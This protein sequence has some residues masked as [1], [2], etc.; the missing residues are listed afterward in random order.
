MLLLPG[1]FGRPGL[2]CRFIHP[3]QDLGFTAD[4]LREG[5]PLGIQHLDA[6][7][8]LLNPRFQRVGVDRL[9]LADEGIQVGPSIMGESLEPGVE[10]FQLLVDDP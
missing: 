9:G 6:L 3:L 5:I 4:R 2:A 1:G 8:K 10:R 7:V